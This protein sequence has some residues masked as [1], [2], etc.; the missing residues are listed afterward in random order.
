MSRHRLAGT[1]RSAGFT[2]ME[3]LVVMSLLSLV[4]LALGS[5]LRTIAQT[6]ER[7]D[8]RLSRA[9]EMRIAVSFLRST[10]GRVSARKVT[11]PPPAKTGVMFATGPQAV[12]W[13]GVMPAR[14]GA[15]GRYFFRLALERQEQG[16]AL[17]IRFVPWVDQP[18]FPDWARA[19]SRVLVQDVQALSL[20]YA[21]ARGT[22]PGW[23]ASWQNAERLPDQVQLD[24]ETAHAAWPVINL[25]M[26]VMPN[27][28]PA[29][30]GG[31][32]FGA[33]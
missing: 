17:V 27:S 21:D 30:M 1:S 31:A 11:P 33:S 14:Y 8:Q 20:R 2:L 22:E 9:D 26:R 7:I 29:A 3:V 4:M 19:E 18:E 32:A 5:S 15:G 24:I 25:P 13:V 6:E 28:D 12:A 10:L 23:S 16:Q